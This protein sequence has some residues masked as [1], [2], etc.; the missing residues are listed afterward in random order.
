R[1]AGGAFF[2]LVVARQVAGDRLPALPLVRRAEDDVGAGV[3]H[4]GIE[5]RQHYGE[6]PLE[7][8]LQV[9]GAPPHRVVG[10]REDV[11]LL[12]GAGVEP[13]EVAVTA[14]V[15][16][17]GVVG[18]RRDPAALT[19]AHLVP[20]LLA[21]RPAV[22]AA[23]DAHGAVILLRA[24]DLVRHVGGGDHVIELRGRLIV[25]PRPRRAAVIAYVRAAVVAVDHAGGIVGR[26][27]QPVMVAM[28]RAQRRERAA[29][30][31]RAIHPGVQHVDRL[32]ILG[33]GVD[34]GVVPGALPE[35]ALVVGPPPRLAAV[36]GAEHAARVR[37]HDS[38]DPIMVRGHSYT[39][40]ADRAL[41][42]PF[43]AGELFPGVAAVGGLEEPG[44][45]PAAR[46]VPRPA[47]RLPDRSV[48]N[49][50]IGGVHC[51]IDGAGGVGPEQHF[52]PRLAAVLGPEHAALRIWPERV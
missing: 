9:R 35:I 37:I 45:G 19:P 2:R 44:A 5:R 43:V 22:G 10:P 40:L 49:T 36:V 38:P 28:G 34:V 42:H 13:R 1:P 4:V 16:D 25:L 8:V 21:D 48:E 14:G 32:G 41:G 18:S 33:I 23:R 47:P 50:R 20:V 51:E 39:D 52:L 24:A 46:H 11:A 6:R 26:G 31:H 27:P 12:A 17:V 30:V 7:A 15:H 3:Q 29:A